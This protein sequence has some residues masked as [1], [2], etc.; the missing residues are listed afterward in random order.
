MRRSLLVASLV[1]L[2]AAEAS[3]ASDLKIVYENPRFQSH[4][5]V[6]DS[7]S[8]MDVDSMRPE[9]S[10]VATMWWAVRFSDNDTIYLGEKPAVGREAR[11]DSLLQAYIPGTMGLTFSRSRDA[12]GNISCGYASLLFVSPYAEPSI[13]PG[14]RARYSDN[15]DFSGDSLIYTDAYVNWTCNQW[16]QSEAPIP[17]GTIG[18]GR[19][20]VRWSGFVNIPV[21]GIWKFCVDS[22]DGAR[23]WV[24]GAKLVDRWTTGL[25]RV[26]A[27]GQ[28]SLVS[29]WRPLVL[30]YYQDGG[31]C[32]ATLYW[33]PPGA[34]EA[35]VPATA[36]G[37]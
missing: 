9:S 14:L 13:Q 29:G 19:F 23:L 1:F 32:G 15:P 3:A 27:C 2:V 28:A 36:L 17:H 35:I 37:H 31:G 11:L 30:E 33:T 25:S 7:F 8:C 10:L 20:S 21:D 4:L 26:K 16:P 24:G 18:P 34:L 5:A 6:A 22:D 12:A